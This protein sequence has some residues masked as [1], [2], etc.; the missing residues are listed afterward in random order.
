LERLNDPIEDQTGRLE[1]LLH[2]LRDE[3]PRCGG[4]EVPDDEDGRQRPEEHHGVEGPRAVGQD[5]SG[6]S[7]HEQQTVHEQTGERR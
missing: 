4:G 3:N 7:A 2:F 1:C 6:P 5:H